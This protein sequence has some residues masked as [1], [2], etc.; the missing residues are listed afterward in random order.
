MPKNKLKKS[1]HLV[2]NVNASEREPSHERESMRKL[3]NASNGIMKAVCVPT[4]LGR[5]ARMNFVSLFLPNAKIGCTNPCY[6]HLCPPRPTP[7]LLRLPNSQHQ[8][9]EFFLF[10][11]ED[12]KK[13]KLVLQVDQPTITK[14]K[15]PPNGFSI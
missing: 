14:E 13:P 2:L 4:M 7:F 1:T 8:I 3:N 6:F 11:E 12:Q 10:N 9:L 5:T 15:E